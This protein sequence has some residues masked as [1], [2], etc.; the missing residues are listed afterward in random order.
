M[1]QDDQRQADVEQ[2]LAAAVVYCFAANT[3]AISILIDKISRAAGRTETFES[4]A[5]Y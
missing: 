1:Q 5:E 2:G 4:L 3:R